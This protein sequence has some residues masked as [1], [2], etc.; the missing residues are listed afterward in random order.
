MTDTQI[1]HESFLEDVNN[2]LNTGEITNLYA[3]EDFD[4]MYSALA[5]VNQ[6]LKRPETKDC[7]YQTFIERVRDNFHIILCMSPVGD[8]LRIRCRKFPSLVNC[9]TLDWFDNWPEEALLSVSQ[10]FLSNV[11]GE[12]LA[13]TKESQDEIRAKLSKMFT[14]VH[15]SVEDMSTQFYDEMR[16]KVYVT[17][18]SYLDGIQMYLMQLQQ[19]RDEART[20]INRLV[21]GCK[22]LKDTNA[23]IADLQVSLATLIPKLEEENIKSGLKS[24]EIKDNKVI[25]FQK[26]AVVEEESAYVQAE[27]NKIEALKRENDIELAKCKPALEEAERAVG[28][29]NKDNITELKTFK[30]PP[31]VVEL[32]LRCVFLYLGYPKQEWKQALT[33]ISDI[34]FLDRLKHY[35]SK[36]IPQKTLLA[37]KQ[38]VLQDNWNPQ[39]MTVKSKVAGGL[40]KWCK[41]IY[42]YAEAWKIV[43]PKEQK[44][45]ELT[46]KLKGAE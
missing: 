27:A 40:A 34:K 39:E 18:K 45:R 31:E 24:V 37:V 8:S 21:N 43:K 3:K 2:I 44:Q 30:Q 1:M 4:R 20:N 22:K 26:E 16:R 17:P 46:E 25:A 15:K 38:M 6:Q 36:N 19:Q 12:Q 28:E 23:Q 7:I 10:K 32:V 33:I 5:K 41:A 13:M 9:C 29:L 14:Q 35:D 11:A 42:E